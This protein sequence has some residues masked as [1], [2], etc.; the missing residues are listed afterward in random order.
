MFFSMV[1]L[2]KKTFFKHLYWVYFLTLG[3]SLI[4]VALI[5]LAPYLLSKN[6][7]IGY[8]VYAVFAPFCHQSPERCF[9]LWGYP[10]AVCGRCTG[11]YLGFLLGTLIYPLTGA[12]ARPVIP[13]V[14][15]FLLCSLP[16]SLDTL[17]NFF[18]FWPTPI[19][20]RWATGLI[21]GIILPF[22]F[23]YGL[24]EALSRKSH[25]ST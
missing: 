5:L 11:I 6:Q 21:W 7:R 13:R 17:G 12:L 25:S 22:Y 14:S 2:K 19:W 24:S 18:H 3:L 8:L 9:F 20:G 4:I 16:I 10:L 1:V 15:Y 23:I